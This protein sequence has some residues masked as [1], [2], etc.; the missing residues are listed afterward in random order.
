M[1]QITIKNNLGEEIELLQANNPEYINGAKEG[2]NI[3]LKLLAEE[4]ELE[5]G[6]EVVSYHINN[7]DHQSTRSYIEENH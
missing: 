2:C 7:N 4:M 1:Y 3:L 6:Y 5:D